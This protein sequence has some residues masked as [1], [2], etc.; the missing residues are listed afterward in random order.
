MRRPLT[1]AVVSA[2]LFVASCSGSASQ[3]SGEQ[4]PAPQTT[5]VAGT[6]AAPPPPQ[7]DRTVWAVGDSIM[8][9]ASEAL[10]SHD[11]DM[12]IN[13]ETGRKFSSGLR[14]LEDLLEDSSP[15]DVLV[16]AL[17]TNNGATPEEIDALLALGENIDEI[18]LVNVV[19]P[20]GWEADT[21]TTILQ[22]AAANNVVSF[23]DWNAT[24]NGEKALFRSDGYHPS[25][26]GALLWAEL[27]VAEIFDS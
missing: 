18:I 1:I 23:V 22:A 24:A 6:D 20:R 5:T 14:V 10:V 7:D 13:A 26:D 25:T 17:G 8:V 12:V 9:A 16:F 3:I 2:V 11:P 4:P 21:N 27:I 15:P 19:V